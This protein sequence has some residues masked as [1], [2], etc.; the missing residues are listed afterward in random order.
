[1]PDFARWFFAVVATG[2]IIGVSHTVGFCR[3][4]ARGLDHASEDALEILRKV[5]K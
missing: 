2:I 4:Y 3:G 1:M 5:L